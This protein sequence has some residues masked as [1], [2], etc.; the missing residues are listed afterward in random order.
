MLSIST[1]LNQVSLFLIKTSFNKGYF[2]EFNVGKNHSKQDYTRD[3]STE[4][5]SIQSN[6]SF[7]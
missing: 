1:L 3:Y 4:Q 7:S 6:Q 2:I 5:Y